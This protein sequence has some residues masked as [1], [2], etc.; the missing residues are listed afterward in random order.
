[1]DGRLPTSLQGLSTHRHPTTNSDSDDGGAEI[2]ETLTTREAGSGSRAT[3][4]C[5]IPTV[6]EMGREINTQSAALQRLTGQ[7]PLTTIIETK[8]DGGESM[9]TADN[10][11]R[12]R[13]HYSYLGLLDDGVWVGGQHL[14]GLGRHTAAHQRPRQV[15]ALQLSIRHVLGNR[16]DYQHAACKASDLPQCGGARRGA[17]D[18]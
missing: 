15:P 5:W 17:N 12:G 4:A 18:H 1:M 16:G 6:T 13:R 14:G 9:D 3:L 7:E 2:K 11:R 10:E 8:G